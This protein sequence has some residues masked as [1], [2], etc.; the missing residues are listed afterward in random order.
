MGAVY[1]YHLTR[2]PLEATLP[3]LLAKARGAGWRVLV[4]GQTDARMDWL[5]E[6]LW[7]GAED[8]FLPHG[9]DGG[10]FDADQPV[11][12]TTAATPATA[13]CLM[14][15]EGAEVSP[16][17]VQACQRVCILFDGNDAAAVETARGQWRALTEAGCAAQYWSQESGSWAKKAESPAA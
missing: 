15:V 7:L 9:R 10:P 11:L 14:A 13:A 12:L 4:R 17:E 2:S 6:K 5:D 16:D 1:F 8:Q 3:M